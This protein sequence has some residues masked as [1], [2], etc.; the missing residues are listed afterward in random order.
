MNNNSI[1]TRLF[2]ALGIIISILL[3]VIGF[4][5]QQTYSLILRVEDNSNTT[6]E[7]TIMLK[8]K[9]DNIQDVYNLKFDN[10]NTKIET[11]ETRLNNHDDKINKLER[12]K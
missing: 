9:I 3:A 11:H 8:E 10:I 4:F 5:L 6:R 7:I 1:N 12:R 2:N